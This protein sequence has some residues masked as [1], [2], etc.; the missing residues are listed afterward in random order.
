MGPIEDEIVRGLR[1]QGVLLWRPAAT[2][3]SMEL[4]AIDDSN[5]DLYQ[6]QITQRGRPRS[7]ADG[8]PRAAFP[9]DTR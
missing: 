6:T 2:D 4:E 3:S 8:T 9:A 7:P 1:K 5:S